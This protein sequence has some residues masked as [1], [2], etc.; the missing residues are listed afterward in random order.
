[1]ILVCPDCSA[2]YLV[3]ATVFSAGPRLVRCARCSH[4]WMADTPSNTT[5]VL[6][7]PSF[8]KKE[9]FSSPEVE[10]ERAPPPADPS[11]LPVIWSNPLWVKAKRFL[12][13]ACLLFAALVLL[14]GALDR[15]AI[16]EKWPVVE[17]LY[18]YVG[19][20]IYHLGEG[21][22]FVQVRSEKRY[23]DGETRLIV[24]GM[25]VNESGIEQ[26]VPDLKVIALG[27]DGHQ[28]Q[29]WQAR[30]KASSLGPRKAIAFET[31]A[32]AGEGAITEINLSFMGEA[33]HDTK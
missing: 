17:K 19:L 10:H 2:R 6:P 26:P 8:E 16:A 3:P 20:P 1:M 33:Q 4:Q 30:P 9:S 14:W 31:S 23:E 29:S 28:N 15:Q 7:D 21:L 13:L 12:K 11:K 22:R 32:K 24:E 18:D 5:P 27:P 25:I